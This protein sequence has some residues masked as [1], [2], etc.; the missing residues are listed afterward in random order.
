MSYRISNSDAEPNATQRNRLN[1]L[2]VF[3]PAPSAMLEGI[4]IAA[5]L[6]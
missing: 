6:I 5:L 4:D 1:S 3:L 2:G